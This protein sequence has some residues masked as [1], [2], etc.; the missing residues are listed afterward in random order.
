[1]VKNPPA[2]QRDAGDVVLIP[3][4]ERFPGKEMVARCS[5]LAWKIPLTE[6]PDGLSPWGH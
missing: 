1:M 4:L 6:E 2:M 3:E 5:I